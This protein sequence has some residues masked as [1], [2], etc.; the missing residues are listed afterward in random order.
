MNRGPQ[1]AR[2]PQAPQQQARPQPEAPYGDEQQFKEDDI[3]F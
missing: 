3:P 2:G 1:P